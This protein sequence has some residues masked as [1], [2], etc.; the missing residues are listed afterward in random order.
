M[1]TE[2]LTRFNN[3]VAADPALQAKVQSLNSEASRELAQRLA[4]LSTEA[5]A[6]FTAEEFLDQATSQVSALTDEQL[7]AV[8]GGVNSAELGSIALSV[9][10][11]GIACAAFAIE[12]Q[13]RVGR[14]VA[15]FGGG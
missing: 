10:T 14:P 1:S 6:P 15:C 9:F 13:V 2:N 7:D 4:A 3:A 11:L 8:A 5:G 12:S